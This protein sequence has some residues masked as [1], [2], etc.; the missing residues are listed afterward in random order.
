MELYQLTTKVGDRVAGLYIK[1]FRS[2]GVTLLFSHGNAV[3]LGLLRD[4]ALALSCELQVNIFAYDYSGFGASTG[5]STEENIYHNI[6]AV[7]QFLTV[8]LQVPRSK[9]ILYGQSIGTAPTMELASKT[10]HLRGVVLHSP[11]LSG[12]RVFFPDWRWYPVDAFSN[13][14]KA[15]RISSPV[16]IMHGLNDEIIDINQAMALHRLLGH[17][18]VMPLFIAGAGHNN[19]ECYPEYTF[20]LREFLDHVEACQMNKTVVLEEDVDSPRPHND[21]DPSSPE[22]DCTGHNALC[23]GIGSIF[24]KLRLIQ[25]QEAPKSMKITPRGTPS[26]SA[27]R[28]NDSMLRT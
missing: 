23:I 19:M 11:F 9:I 4:H 26:A 14:D 21:A 1:H 6:E 17:V 28:S 24:A 13:C 2:K 7:F 10:K 25:D 18:S 12:A 8:E 22:A 16:L 27:S 3:D 15:Q 5:T 20:R